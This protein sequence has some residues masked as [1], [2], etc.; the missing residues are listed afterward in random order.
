MIEWSESQL[1]IRDAIRRF[2][3]AEVERGNDTQLLTPDLQP[4]PSF[5]G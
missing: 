5:V 2:V 4:F 3:E 1:M